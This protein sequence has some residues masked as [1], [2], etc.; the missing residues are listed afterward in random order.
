MDRS[1]TFTN[2]ENQTVLGRLSKENGTLSFKDSDG[3]VFGIDE[4]L[5]GSVAILGPDPG[6]DMPPVALELRDAAQAAGV[7]VSFDRERHGGDRTIRVK[8]SGKHRQRR[9]RRQRAV[10]LSPDDAVSEPE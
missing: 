5:G 10:S 3:N 4:L 8:R 2:K 7:K 6:Q 1:A 9:Q